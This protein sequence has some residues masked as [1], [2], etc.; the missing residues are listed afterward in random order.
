MNKFK[1]KKLYKSPDL[2][3]FNTRKYLKNNNQNNAHTIE[4]KRHINT[5]SNNN[6][7]LIPYLLLNKRKI[8]I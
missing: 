1:K 3:R 4:N 8:N 2:T 6:N 5:I 7:N